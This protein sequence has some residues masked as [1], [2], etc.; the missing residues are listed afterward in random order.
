MF[1]CELLPIFVVEAGKKVEPYGTVPNTEKFRLFRSLGQSELSRKFF[2]TAQM[3]Q[4]N[5]EKNYCPEFFSSIYE[6]ML[7]TLIFL[8]LTNT[9]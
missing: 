1:S 3:D 4:N 8:I 7:Y 2:R 5:I 6:N 9:G